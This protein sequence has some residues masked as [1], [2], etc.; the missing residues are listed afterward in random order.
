MKFLL[1]VSRSLL[2]LSL[3]SLVFIATSAVAISRGGWFVSMKEEVPPE[4]SIPNPVLS[5]N[6]SFPIIS[7]RAALA[8]DLDSGVALYEKDPENSLLPASTTKIATALVAM[9][10][11]PEDAVLKVGKI[12]IEGQKMGLV[13][14]EEITARDLLYGLLVFSAN[15]AAEVLAENFPG[16][17]ELFIASMNL[18]VKD[19]QL[20]NTNFTN[21]SG[22]DGEGQ[23]TTAKDL[24]RLSTVA[25]K[26][27]RFA[28]IVRQKEIEVKSTDGRIIHELVTTNELLGNVEGVLGV[29]TGWTEDA[30]E[31]L[32]TYIEKDGRRVMIALLASQDR[33]GE[34][35][36][37]IGWIFGNY[38]WKEVALPN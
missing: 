11:Y 2:L 8:V 13:E 9:D 21:P 17:R 18:K 37:L 34:T 10:Y 36:E 24:V 26:N 20:E 32:V 16:G 12:Q 3:V 27:P 31:N 19:L 38:K 14:G 23:F 33:F 28:E 1:G 5:E 29:K 30:R 15:D 6:T 35:K 4:S 25:M 22:L 7:A